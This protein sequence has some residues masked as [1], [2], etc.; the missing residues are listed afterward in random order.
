MQISSSICSEII[1]VLNQYLGV[2]KYLIV[3]VKKKN[4][5]SEVIFCLSA[6]VPGPLNLRS[7]DI[8]TDSFEVG[9]DHSANDIVLYRLSW[10]PFTGGDKK[11]VSNKNIWYVKLFVLD[12][13]FLKRF[14]FSRIRIEM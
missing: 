5:Y 7:S 6:P 1:S 12:S 13:G 11:E 3:K 14:S 9:W 10:A 2:C 8:S 4:I